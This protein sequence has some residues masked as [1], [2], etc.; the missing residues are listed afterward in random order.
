MI[1][2]VVGE[3]LEA[4]FSEM[5]A[6]VITI[7]EKKIWGWQILVTNRVGEGQVAVL[8]ERKLVL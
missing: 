4:E 5:Q 6:L 8:Y 7:V 2:G 3:P 1:L